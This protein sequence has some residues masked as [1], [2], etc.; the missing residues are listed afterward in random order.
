MLN[1]SV[2]SGAT[3]CSETAHIVRAIELNKWRGHYLTGGKESARGNLEQN[4]GGPSCL[5]TTDIHI[6]NSKL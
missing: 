5:S 3:T 2:N 6:G 1:T 4:P